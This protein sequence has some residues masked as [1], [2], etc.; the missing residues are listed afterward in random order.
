MELSSQLPKK[1]MSSVDKEGRHCVSAGRKES[2]EEQGKLTAVHNVSTVMDMKQR[3]KDENKKLKEIVQEITEWVGLDYSQIMEKGGLTLI[4][5]SLQKILKS[6]VIAEKENGKS[7]ITNS[8]LS[9]KL[10]DEITCYQNQCHDLKEEMTEVEEKQKLCKVNYQDPQAELGRQLFEESKERRCWRIC[11]PL[12]EL[13]SG[14]RMLDRMTGAWTC[15]PL[16]GPGLLDKAG[17]LLQQRPQN[18]SNSYARDLLE[19]IHC[20][21]PVEKLDVPLHNGDRSYGRESY[22]LQ[23]SKQG[24]MEKVLPCLEDVHKETCSGKE[25]GISSDTSTTSLTLLVS[26]QSHESAAEK[27]NCEEGL[28]ADY[29]RGL[30]TKDDLL[31]NEIPQETCSVKRVCSCFNKEESREDHGIEFNQSPGPSFTTVG[32]ENDKGTFAFK[33]LICELQDEVAF[34]QDQCCELREELVNLKKKWKF[35]E[36]EKQDLQAE[37]GRQLFLESKERRCSKIY[38]PPSG[39]ADGTSMPGRVRGASHDLSVTGAKLLGGAGPLN[40]SGEE[41]GLKVACGAGDERDREG[42]YESSLH[43]GAEEQFNFNHHFNGTVDGAVNLPDRVQDSTMPVDITG[44]NQVSLPCGDT[45]QRQNISGAGI[46]A[47]KDT[48]TDQSDCLVGNQSSTWEHLGARPRDRLIP[49]ARRSP[50]PSSSHSSFSNLAP[51]QVAGPVAHGV[52]N[53]FIA[54]H[55]EDKHL[56]ESLYYTNAQMLTENSSS[57]RASLGD[58]MINLMDSNRSKPYCGHVA[59]RPDPVSQM[60]SSLSPQ[61]SGAYKIRR[62]SMC[63][64]EREIRAERGLQTTTWIL[65]SL[66]S[67]HNSYQASEEGIEAAEARIQARWPWFGRWFCTCADGMHNNQDVDVIC[68]DCI[69]YKYCGPCRGRPQS[70]HDECCLCMQDTFSGLQVLP[71][72][73]KIHLQ[74]LIWLIQRNVLHCPA[75]LS[76]FVPTS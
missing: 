7:T 33:S 22:A 74:C 55:S 20:F 71:C 73:H 9:C 61:T 48:A 66:E 23:E 69:M 58:S 13:V 32:R 21:D 18:I 47:P 68:T 35:C 43:D 24:L 11:E 62:P 41:F 56:H 28:V 42:S 12:N 75:C 15:K 1:M 25:T 72:S 17:F 46:T 59:F 36:D 31:P 70:G 8:N 4:Q 19:G 65:Q 10:Q 60:H 53:V 27:S 64:E 16:G 54:R 5:H 39:H 51:G 50:E 45:T 26:S 76:T 40:K 34:Y 37:V 29:H 6:F 63:E 44:V 2:S 52:A 14:R 3:L 67:P 49:T 57:H 30:E 38:Q